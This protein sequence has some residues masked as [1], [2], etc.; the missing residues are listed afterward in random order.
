MLCVCIY[1]YIYTHTCV[2]VC[3]YAYTR[4]CV[5]IYVHTQSY[6]LFRIRHNKLGYYH[7]TDENKQIK[8]IELTEGHEA[9]KQ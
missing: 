6:I 1:I 5:Y 4:V 3:V 2:C 8:T 7:L 9:S